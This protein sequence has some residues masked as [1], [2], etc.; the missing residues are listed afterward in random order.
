MQTTP[1]QAPIPVRIVPRTWKPTV[2]GILDIVSGAS[3][4]IAAFVILFIVLVINS[5]SNWA[6]I[7]EE[8]FAPFTMGTVVALGFVFAVIGAALG[9]LQIVGGIFSLQR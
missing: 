7:S 6:G 2:A 5:A 1:P 8:D 9:A 3:T 4:I